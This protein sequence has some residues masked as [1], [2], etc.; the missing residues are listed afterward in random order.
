MGEPVWVRRVVSVSMTEATPRS[1]TVTVPSGFT[2]TFRGLRSRW[3]IGTACTAL[4][5][6][7]SCA[8]TATAHC[9]GYGSCS[10]RWSERS[11]PSTYCM[12]RKSSSSSLP[13]SWTV[14]RPGWSTCAVTRHSR[15]KRRRS[16]SAS[17]PATLSGRSSSTAT[18]RSSR[19]S[20]AVQTWPMPPW[21][22]S[23]DSSYRSAMTRPVA[24][25]T[26]RPRGRRHRRGCRCRSHST[27]AAAVAVVLAQVVAELVE[28]GADLVDTGG[29]GPL[30]RGRYGAV[31]DG[32]R[33]DRR[34][35]HGGL[36]PGP[37]VRVRRRGRVP[38]PGGHGRGLGRRVTGVRALPV[39]GPYVHDQEVDAG[40]GAQEQHDG[41]GGVAP[42]VALRHR[43]DHR[44]A[45][46]GHRQTRP[47]RRPVEPPATQEGDPEQRHARQDAGTRGRGDGEQH[48]QGDDGART[49][50]RGRRAGAVMTAPGPGDANRGRTDEW[51]VSMSKFGIKIRCRGSSV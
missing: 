14:T 46:D 41:E 45:R 17:W 36:R 22:M 43:A 34:A 5:T 15:T 3:T 20:Y 11:A 21:P 51:Q 18:R 39:V 50:G 2:I 19:W 44:E 42:G 16:S 24:R 10:V 47:G 33:G 29:R 12:T 23:V 28:F 1:R 4:S 37:H 40:D 49:A 30:R 35:G 7:H 38:V 32:W 13:A 25:L 48:S 31:R 27:A 9:Q 8:A 26:V 6:A